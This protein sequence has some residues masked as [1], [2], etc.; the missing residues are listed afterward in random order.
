VWLERSR[1]KTT[2]AIMDKLLGSERE[3]K[4]LDDA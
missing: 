3:R 2:L 1:R 4:K